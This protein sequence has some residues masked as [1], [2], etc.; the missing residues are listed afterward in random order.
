M[1]KWT[2]SGNMVSYFDY[3][4]RVKGQHDKISRWPTTLFGE[5]GNDK[6]LWNILED[7]NGKV[8]CVWVLIILHQN[9]IMTSP[10]RNDSPIFIIWIDFW[11][12]SSFQLWI[13][14]RAIYLFSVNTDINR[15]WIG[16]LATNR[17][18]KFFE[19]GRKFK[20]WAIETLLFIE[21]SLIKVNGRD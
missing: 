9:L 3:G 15:F 2:Q 12:C 8:L 4:S 5:I 13:C 14:P 18:V 7:P 10:W 1:T 11:L 16:N 19:N 6:I 20:F 17:K 21:F